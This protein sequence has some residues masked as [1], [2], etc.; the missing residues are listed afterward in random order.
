M[1]IKLKILDYI[2][3]IFPS[4]YHGVFNFYSVQKLRPYIIW[5]QNQ[6]TL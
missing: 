4:S 1:Y 6:P 2:L 5:H 3:F